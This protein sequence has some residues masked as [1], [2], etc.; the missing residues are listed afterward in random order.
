MKY[1][2]AMHI[3]FAL[4]HMAALYFGSGVE[5]YGGSLGFLANTPLGRMVGDGATDP[6]IEST[7]NFKQIFD[8]IKNLGDTLNGL[9][10]FNYGIVTDH[11][12]PEDGLLYWLAVVFRVI[13]WA[14]SLHLGASIAQMV[15]QS[16]I[17][18]S[19]AGLAVVTGIVGIGGA[20]SALGI[21]T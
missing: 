12:Q 19:N 2:A 1:F 18:Q 10:S 7:T 11:F 21:T 5:N 16:G 9:F 13:G 17:L 14:A 6:Y 15:F 3:A 8:F 4:V 20:L